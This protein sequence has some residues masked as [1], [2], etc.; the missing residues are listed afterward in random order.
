M[1]S[2]A[3]V[4]SPVLKA[5]E[6]IRTDHESGAR[7]LAIKALNALQL[8]LESYNYSA[9][10]DVDGSKW[11]NIINCAWQ[12][13]QS[14]PSMKAAIQTTILRAL[15]TIRQASDPERTI[16]DLIHEEE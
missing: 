7:Q 2:P 16:A 14:R 9:P 15:H 5:I 1:S 3:L 11:R 13:S 8:A 10:A 6:D 12:I 4:P